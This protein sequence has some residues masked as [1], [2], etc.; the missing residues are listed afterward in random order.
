MV[1]VIG[2]LKGMKREYQLII[3]IIISRLS[4]SDARVAESD[5]NDHI[6]ALLL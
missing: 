3:I 6:H 2:W 4:G 5:G 1:Q